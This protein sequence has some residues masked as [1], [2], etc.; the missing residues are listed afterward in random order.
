MRQTSEG[1]IRIGCL[2]ALGAAVVSA[3]TTGRPSRASSGTRPEAC[4]QPHGHRD[5][6]GCGH[7]ADG[8][9]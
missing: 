7:S 6:R 1:I 4:C 2:M 3:Q 5:R 8:H 9:H